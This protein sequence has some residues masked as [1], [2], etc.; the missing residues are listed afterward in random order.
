MKTKKI[1]RVNETKSWYFEK[2]N[3]SDESLTK[4]PEK[5]KEDPSQQN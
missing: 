3:K 4:H 5:G 2:I 1:Q